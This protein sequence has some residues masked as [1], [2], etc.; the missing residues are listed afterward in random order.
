MRVQYLSILTG[1][2]RARVAPSTG[3][4]VPG[5]HSDL[6]ITL[7]R[8][9]VKNQFGWGPT[10]RAVWDSLDSLAADGARRAAVPLARRAPVGVGLRSALASFSSG[11]EHLQR[12]SACSEASEGPAGDGA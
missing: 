9:A 10:R 11:I 7:S 8:S 1:A 2:C 6:Q 4:R 3:T 12:G 5:A